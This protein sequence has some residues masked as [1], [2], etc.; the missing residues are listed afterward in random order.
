MLEAS[1]VRSD[2]SAPE[3]RIHSPRCPIPGHAEAPEKSR[4]GF[5]SIA[6]WATQMRC[7]AACARNRGRAGAY[8]EAAA[9]CA[10]AQISLPPCSLTEPK[11]L[12]ALLERRILIWTAPWARH[13]G[14]QALGERFPRRRFASSRAS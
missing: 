9:A 7:S 10:L 5:P 14:L 1:A 6:L 8:V 4:T 13:P 3:V 2:E 11:E 12:K